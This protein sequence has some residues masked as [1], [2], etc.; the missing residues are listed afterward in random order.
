MADKKYM[1]DGLLKEY[2][3]PKDTSPLAE[4]FKMQ[5]LFGSKFVN[6][7][8]LA[9]IKTVEDPSWGI[10]EDWYKDF[11]DCITDE[12]S[13]VLNWLPWKHWKDYSKFELKPL[14][15]KFELIDILHFVVFELLLC[16]YTPDDLCKIMLDVPVGKNCPTDLERLMNHAVEDSFLKDQYYKDEKAEATRVGLRNLH[17]TLG[18]CYKFPYRK[19]LY[20]TLFYH[21]LVLFGVWDMTAQDVYSYYMSKNKENFDRQTRGY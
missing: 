1:G 12:C 14:E 20:V 10:K 13:E 5:R 3:L 4:I 16:N 9:K 17:I 11:L 2:P 8:E 7:D 19:S 21:L 6:F 15:I 18:E